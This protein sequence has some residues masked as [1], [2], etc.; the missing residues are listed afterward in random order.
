M[1]LFNRLFINIII[2]VVVVVVGFYS[3]YSFYYVP[4]YF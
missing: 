3:L 4:S 2:A 1:F